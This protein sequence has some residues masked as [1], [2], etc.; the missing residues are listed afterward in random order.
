MRTAAPIIA[1]AICLIGAAASPTGQTPTSPGAAD[2][3]APRTD[4]NSQIAHQ[5]LLQ[6]A[7]AGGID[8][9][10]IGDSIARRWGALDYPAYLANWKENFFGW[11]AADFGWGAD[12]IE[13]ILWRLDNGELDG[14]NPK[15]FV[16]LAG[17]NN[18][19]ARPGNAARIA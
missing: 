4:Q 9:Y 8:V 19:G 2:R 6:K 7:K 11:N 3:P 15:V 16:I 14:V 12:R 13:N 10:F 1:F 17:T 18:I 5:Q